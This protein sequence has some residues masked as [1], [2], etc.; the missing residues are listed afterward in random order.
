[1][2]KRFRFARKAMLVRLLTHPVGKVLLTFSLLAGTAGLLTFTYYY[3]KYSRLIEQKLSSGPFQ[4]TAKVFAAP[5]VVSTGDEIS[6]QEIIEQLTRSGYSESHT[7]PLGWYRLREDAVEIFPGPD[8][9]FDRE[10]GLI[11]FSNGRVSRII[12]THD[13][14]E[15]TLYMLEPELITNLFDRN[16]EKRRLV[17]FSGIPEVLIQAVVA[18]EDKRFFQ[19]SG[20]DPFRIVK[21]AYVDLKAGRLE[22]GAS[23]LSMQLARSLWLDLRKTWRR[24]AAEV[25]I[26]LHLEQKLTKEQ[27]FEYYANQVD[28]GRRGSFS[29]RGFGQGAQAYFGKDIGDL[30]LAEAATLAGVIQ[31]PSYTN[32]VRWPERARLRRNVVLW[33]MRENGF[34]TDE[35][36]AEAASSP[37]GVVRGSSESTD[38]PYFVDLV[39]N[40]LQDRFQGHDFQGYFYRIY[41]T[42]DLNLQRAAAEAVRLG[43]Q[44]VEEQLRRQRKKG[45][46][47]LPEAQVALVALDP[48]TGDIKALIGGRNYGLTQLNRTLAKRQPGSAFKPFV[49]AAALRTALRGNPKPLTTQTT[50]VDEPTTF[51]FDDKPYTPSNY[52]NE[53]RGVV[54]FRQA[55]AKSMNVPTVKVAEMVG[56]QAVVDLAVL[57]GMNLRIQPTPAVALGAYEV[58]PIEVAGSYTVFANEGVYAKPN[59]IKLIRDENGHVIYT[60]EPMRR[61]VLDP[62]VAYLMAN[63]LENVLRRGTGVGV[64]AR[65]FLLPAAGKTGTS[66]DQSG[67]ASMTIGN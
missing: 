26:T 55:L 32:P 34:I 47:N 56:Y 66:H 13:N 49:Y 7:N 20:F 38:A 45:A 48:R 65:G 15:R 23:T 57:A 51:L 21:A 27:I 53:Y 62:R 10:G 11:R 64:R 18:V 29:I 39:N 60:E 16:R 5:G 24:K 12:S 19:H 25:L 42:L 6:A 40:D 67:W 61:R 33:L 44:E 4:S 46:E 8:S 9:Y 50:V 17:S 36:Y 3:V 2:A 63:L 54:T 58:T 59:W 37:L 35:E 31:R 52:H 30:T 1:V 28:L 41:T 14:T 22:E 43:M